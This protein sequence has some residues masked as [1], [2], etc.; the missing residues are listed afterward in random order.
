MAPFTVREKQQHKKG[1]QRPFI[2][3]QE[4]EQDGWRRAEREGET[5]SIFLS[6]QMNISLN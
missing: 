2:K 5:L 3:S 4:D 1:F 6:H